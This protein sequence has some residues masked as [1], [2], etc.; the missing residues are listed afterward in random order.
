MRSFRPRVT[1]PR[2]LS[3][4][5]VDTELLLAMCS[6]SLS[7]GCKDALA[8]RHVPIKLQR[9]TSKCWCRL[10]KGT[11][12]TQHVKSM[13]GRE[14]GD[15][16]KIQAQEQKVLTTAAQLLHVRCHLQ[17]LLAP[18]A[19]SLC[20]TIPIFVLNL[21]TLYNLHGDTVAHLDI[22]SSNIMLQEEGCK[23]WDQLRLIDF[24]FSQK[25]SS[26][27]HAH[28]NAT[29]RQRVCEALMARPLH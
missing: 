24:G 29:S 12:L 18:E 20:F 4:M 7:E 2:E 6:Y 16:S 14:S 1:T 10:T 21:Q 22:T 27:K 23:P 9:K 25:C 3:S 19:A 13:R 5:W 8:I 17:A 28:C 15:L 26:G 11:S